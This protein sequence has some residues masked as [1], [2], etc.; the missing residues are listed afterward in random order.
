[1]NGLCQDETAEN[2]LTLEAEDLFRL[3]QVGALDR[4]LRRMV[5]PDVLNDGRRGVRIRDFCRGWARSTMNTLLS[6]PSPS[7]PPALHAPEPAKVRGPHLVADRH[8]PRHAPRHGRPTFTSSAV[9]GQPIR[10]HWSDESYESHVEKHLACE[11]TLRALGFAHPDLARHGDSTPLTSRDVVRALRRGADHP[12]AAG[13][14]ARYQ[15]LAARTLDEAASIGWIVRP[16]TRSLV[17]FSPT[18]FLAV[19]S[20]RCLRTLFVPGIRADETRLQA[21]GYSPAEARAQQ[22]R[23]AAWDEDLRHY[24]A[25]FR[26][27]VRLIRSLP[28]D[29]VAGSCSQYGALKR[30]M[31]GASDLRFDGW[32][33][34]LAKVRVA[35]ASRS[36]DD[37][38]MVSP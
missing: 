13:I 21:A 11:A 22:R 37:E 20:D 5:E 26:P 25:V 30:V 14:R 18:G 35:A 32:L 36:H 6:N 12:E 15:M 34:A 2:G 24:H 10:L 4:G 19:V 28:T 17:A 23:E 38:S 7:N 16:N 33:H 1:M 9:A 3:V 27:A 29:A 31:P 8:A